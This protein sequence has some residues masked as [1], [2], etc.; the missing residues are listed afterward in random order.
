M[1]QKKKNK[2]LGIVPLSAKNVIIIL[3]KAHFVGNR[4]YG[5]YECTHS[6]NRLLLTIKAV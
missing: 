5:F 3:K 4:I 6:K 1:M 2:K